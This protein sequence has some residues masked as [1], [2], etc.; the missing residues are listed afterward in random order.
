MG[1]REV[2][3]MRTGRAFINAATLAAAAFLAAAARA[4]VSLP[5][6]VE[7]VIAEAEGCRSSFS[8]WSFACAALIRRWSRP[9]RA[10]FLPTALIGAGV[11]RIRPRSCNSFISTRTIAGTQ[12]IQLPSSAAAKALRAPPDRRRGDPKCH[13]SA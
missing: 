9:L 1:C 8:R 12:Q 10:L 2:F 6:P 3:V 13:T 5:D 7:R 11:T 4:Q